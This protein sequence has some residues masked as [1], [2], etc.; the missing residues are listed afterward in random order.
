MP[1]PAKTSAEEILAAAVELLEREGQGGLSLRALAAELHLSPN[2]LYRYYPSREALLA[3]VAV[4][5]AQWLL[6]DLQTATGALPQLAHIYLKFAQERP[7]LYD[8]YMTCDSLSAAQRQIYDEHW[9]L[10]VGALAPLAGAH[11]REAAITLWAYLHGLVGLERSGV[12]DVS[13]EKPRNTTDF[14]LGLLLAGLRE[15]AR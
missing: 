8:L 3:A 12:Y 6:T 5:G 1:Y 2:A 9:E 14:G 11:S 7:A 13:A 4:Q 10:V 15:L